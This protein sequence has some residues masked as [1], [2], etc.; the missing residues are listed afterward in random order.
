MIPCGDLPPHP[1]F[2]VRKCKARQSGPAPTTY[3]TFTLTTSR[4]K[5][6]QYSV[7][8]NGMPRL[9]GR[10]QGLPFDV[11]AHLRYPLRKQPAPS[12]A[13]VRQPV[14]RFDLAPLTSSLFNPKSAFRNGFPLA[15]PPPADDDRTMKTT[16]S[17]GAL[18]S[19]RRRPS[20]GSSRQV[21][22]PAPRLGPVCCSS[23]RAGPGPRSG[24]LYGVP[25][26]P[27]IPPDSPGFPRIPRNPLV[28]HP[29]TNTAPPTTSMTLTR[30]FLRVM[31][32]IRATMM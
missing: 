9:S 12:A 15:L 10:S 32:G 18:R 2:T 4:S 21:Y 27:R 26:F 17:T 25:G 29:S 22:P 6:S 28:A 30:E 5:L 3:D 14:C 13:T 8:R 31:N 7:F 11:T 20:Q 19:Q 23:R 24:K 16:G 1:T